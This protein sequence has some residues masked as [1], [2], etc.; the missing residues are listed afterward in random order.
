VLD[1]GVPRQS[2]TGEILGYVGTCVDITARHE[3][4]DA[5]VYL[6]EVARVLATSLDL[7][8][9][10]HHVVDLLVPH[11]ADYCFVYLGTRDA[12]YQQVAAAHRDPGKMPLLEE[13][14]RRYGPVPGHPHSPVGRSLR[15][16][17]PVLVPDFSPD[18]ARAMTDDPEALRIVQ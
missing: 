3:A 9:V 15:S 13:L 18:A 4:E 6:L 1:S 14:G 11:L 2:A 17:E 16:L 5:Q 12:P 7:D 10:L 8:A